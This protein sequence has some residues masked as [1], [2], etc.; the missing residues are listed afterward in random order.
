[1]EIR[2]APISKAQMLVRR[3]VDEVFGAFIDPAVTTRFWFSKSSGKLA[4]GKQVRWDW[5]MYGVST[6]V[7]VKAIEASWRILIEWD[8]YDSR[9][10]VEWTFVPR[11][12]SETFVTVSERG[13]SGDGDKVVKQALESTGGFNLLLAG[14]KVFLE[15]GI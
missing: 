6:K 7:D 14:L 15:H 11:D 13:F 2:T 8:G 12:G 9:N 3:P 1:M 4:V 10:I 5:E